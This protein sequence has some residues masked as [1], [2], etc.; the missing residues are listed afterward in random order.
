M[1]SSNIICNTLPHTTESQLQPAF[2]PSSP[3]SPSFAAL[4]DKLLSTWSCSWF[5]QP[6]RPG[7][8][9]DWLLN[10][11]IILLSWLVQPPLS[12]PSPSRYTRWTP[13]FQSSSLGP[14]V[15]WFAWEWS[16]FSS[17]HYSWETRWSTLCTAASELSCMVSPWSLTPSWS[18]AESKLQACKSAWMIMLS[19]L[20]CFTSILSCF[21][22]T[23]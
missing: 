6:V 21:S 18:L 11:I 16:H 7:W 19:G 22:F 8:L 12:W 14:L 4:E 15:S 17:S 9:V 23:S 2:F 20:S 3:C 5:S 10:M 13:K 1:I